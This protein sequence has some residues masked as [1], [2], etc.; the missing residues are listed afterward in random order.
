MKRLLT[1]CGLA[2]VTL[3]FGVNAHASVDRWKC[4]S[5][6]IPKFKDDT[7]TFYIDP[8]FWDDDAMRE[9]IRTA[10]E[11]WNSATGW[12]M[13]FRYERGDGG[14][15]FGDGEYQVRRAWLLD[16]GENEFSHLGQSV[17]LPSYDSDQCYWYDSDILLGRKYFSE[18]VER[19]S[20]WSLFSL[21]VHEIGH[22]MG[23]QHN[24]LL[25]SV[26]PAWRNT[27]GL[28]EPEI[29]F[30][31]NL[32]GVSESNTRSNLRAD[33]VVLTDG[34]L[35]D[36]YNVRF[37]FARSV[38]NVPYTVTNM[39]LEY[40]DAI[41]EILYADTV[42]GISFDSAQVLSSFELGIDGG[43]TIS[44]YFEVGVNKS[45]MEDILTTDATLGF[46][47][48]ADNDQNPWDD[49]IAVY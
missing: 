48:V 17:A 32:Y 20:H 31:R 1:L 4:N 16:Y 28:F 15:T 33:H 39:G 12:R 24:S 19:P 45:L 5:G 8:Y 22:A 44:G 18:G 3:L 10:F 43:R 27:R 29:Q 9:E 37:D 40:E 11:T 38:V 14:G 13:S 47:V 41:V 6:D 35:R 26:N 21:M 2:A 23:M 36:Y 49:A 34:Y 30:A 7:A 25:S 46:R 42:E